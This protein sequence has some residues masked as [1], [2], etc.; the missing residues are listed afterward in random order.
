MT[1]TIKLPIDLSD[2][3]DPSYLNERLRTGVT[4]LDWSRVCDA[5]D[6]TLL[7]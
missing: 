3:R 7:P 1:E 5:P 2:L 6:S 4:E